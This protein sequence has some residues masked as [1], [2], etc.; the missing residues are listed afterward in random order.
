MVLSPVCFNLY[1]LFRNVIN[2]RQL[3]I[4]FTA[5]YLSYDEISLYNAII[6][7]IQISMAVDKTI[8]KKRLTSLS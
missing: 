4:L 1:L 5:Y 3:S 6:P 8:K 2:N 7:M